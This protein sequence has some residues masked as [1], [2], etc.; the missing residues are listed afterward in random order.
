MKKIAIKLCLAYALIQLSININA[1]GFHLDES[2]FF[3][4]VADSNGIFVGINEDNLDLR[5]KVWFIPGTG[6]TYGRVLWGFDRGMFQYQGGMNEKGL[7]VDL[8]TTAGY[9]G[10]KQ[11]PAKSNLADSVDIFDYLL[12]NISTVDEAI[13][14]FKKYNIDLSSVMYVFADA[15]RKS[16]IIEVVDGELKILKKNLSYQICTNN[17]QSGIDI[18]NNYP[19]DRW[20]IADQILQE[21]NTPSVDLIRRVLSATSAQFYFVST[22]Y[23]AI[24][25]LVKKKIY[26]Y[27]FHNFEEVV[28]FDLINEL[29][30]GGT[31]YT[32][33]ELFKVQP[34]SFLTHRN[35]GVQW[36]DQRLKQ[37]I[38]EQGIEEGIKELQRM[39]DA[40]RTYNKYIFQEWVIKAVSQQYLEEKKI[41]LAIEV[42]KLNVQEYPESPTVYSD[43]ADAYLKNNNK[44]LAIENYKKALEKDP[45]NKELILI[46]ESL[47]KK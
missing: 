47:E 46:I 13:D 10:W 19:C 3:V 33:K 39:K 16:V 34:Y 44:T 42:F 31:N 40:K 12:R 5:P 15:N 7:M 20:R 11:D 35:I 4:S 28:V 29:A 37:V 30:K 2:C 36:G 45:D 25:D 41:D 22:D 9:T 27:Y 23:S 14:F 17:V 32:L 26:L 1:Q 8:N 38:D 21:Q 6:K 18:P 24:C 43:L